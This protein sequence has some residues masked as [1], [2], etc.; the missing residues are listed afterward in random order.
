MNSFVSNPL[1]LFNIKVHATPT[2]HQDM[3]MQI[4]SFKIK[5]YH[6]FEESN[7]KKEILFHD[8]LLTY[9]GSTVVTSIVSIF[10]MEC[11]SIQNKS[12]EIKQKLE[13]QPQMQKINYLK[14][15]CKAQHRTA[16]TM[17]LLN[18]KHCVLYLT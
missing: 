9:I 12:Q 6:G 17:P 10:W 18:I 15:L 4:C 5:Q 11:K 1:S 8:Q 7:R 2:K 16:L 13:A 3:L 14:Q